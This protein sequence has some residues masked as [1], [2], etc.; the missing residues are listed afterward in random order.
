M[1]NLINY[2]WNLRDLEQI[3][4]FDVDMKKNKS[5]NL[6]PYADATKQY[7]ANEITTTKIRRN[8]FLPEVSENAQFATKISAKR[9]LKTNVKADFDYNDYNS[10]ATQHKMR[11]LIKLSFK[12]FCFQFSGQL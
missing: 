2:F 10:I 4:R 5:E 6:N 12:V 11:N 9:G 8:Q 1:Q 3:T 7:I